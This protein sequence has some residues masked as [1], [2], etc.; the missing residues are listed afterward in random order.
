ML[1]SRFIISRATSRLNPLSYSKVSYQACD[2]FNYLLFFLILKLKSLT[3]P[4]ILHGQAIRINTY[5]YYKT[6]LMCGNEYV[7]IAEDVVKLC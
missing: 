6:P 4:T 3:C 7:S 1:Y 5:N 2:S